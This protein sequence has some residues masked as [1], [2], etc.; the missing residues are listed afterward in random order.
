[1]L[2]GN[3]ENLNQ[4]TGRDY[5]DLAEVV[6]GKCADLHG[7]KLTQA[8]LIKIVLRLLVRSREITDAILKEVASCLASDDDYVKMRR[9]F[10]V[11]N[12]LSLAIMRISK[13]RSRSR[14]QVVQETLEHHW[15]TYLVNICTSL[16]DIGRFL[17]AKTI[18][19]EEDLTYWHAGQVLALIVNAIDIIQNHAFPTSIP[20]NAEKH[21]AVAD[22]THKTE[23]ILQVV[24]RSVNMLQHGEGSSQAVTLRTAAELHILNRLVVNSA[25]S[26]LRPSTNSIVRDIILERLWAVKVQSLFLLTSAIIN[27]KANRK[28]K[29]LC[30]ITDSTLL[31]YKQ[32]VCRALSA[33]FPSRADHKDDSLAF[34]LIRD[35]SLALEVHTLFSGIINSASEE[36]ATSKRTLKKLSCI[37]N[38]ISEALAAYHKQLML[39]E[40]QPLS[41]VCAY[42][43]T[44]LDYIENAL[45]SVRALKQKAT[46][47][48][49]SAGGLLQKLEESLNESGKS[50]SLALQ[51][52]IMSP[53]GGFPSGELDTDISV[54]SC[55]YSTDMSA[56]W[57]AIDEEMWLQGRGGGIGRI[58]MIIL[59][60]SMHETHVVW[61]KTWGGGNQS[62]RLMNFSCQCLPP[63]AAAFYR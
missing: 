57:D 33:F 39:L 63:V 49:H 29:L 60:T 21:C 9:V 28:N 12:Y 25:L 35:L 30:Q 45:K 26:K 48:G 54:L 7:V 43:R 17:E 50:C 24:S 61:L 10:R 47:F 34:F 55:F 13:H 3:M 40:T 6:K 1:M 18:S 22:L 46:M 14:D 5:P 4:S 19:R 32:V 52:E 41:V 20:K 15:S 23:Q 51:D 11:H 36:S 8:E 37:C 58:V 53:Y 42:R 59:W 56:S 31:Y 38:E 2:E 27:G 16:S 44:C 62:N